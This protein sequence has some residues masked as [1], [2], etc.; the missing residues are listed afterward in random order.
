MAAAQT[1]V[2]N[3]FI[4]QKLNSPKGKNFLYLSSLRIAHGNGI[5]VKNLLNRHL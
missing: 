4:Y 3:R 2:N 1:V 5:I